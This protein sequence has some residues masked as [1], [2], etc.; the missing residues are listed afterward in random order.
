MEV[1]LNY[2]K[3]G[4]TLQLPDSW[5]L[6]LIRKKAVPVLPDPA[7]ALRKALLE[8]QGSQ[9]LRREAHGCSSACILICDVTRPVPNGLI[10]P[11]LLD[12][13]IQA[14]LKPEN[15]K[16]VV[17]TGL[18]RPNLG[19]ELADVVGS[20][21]VLNTV[22][23]VNHFARRDQDHV[24]LG[25]TLRGTPVKIDKRFVHADL[26]IAVGL[27]EPHFM[28]GYSGGRK[29]VVPGVA[30]AETITRL[31]TA[32]FL[33][34]CRAMNCLLERNPLHMEQMEIMS[35]IGRSLAVNVVITE[36]RQISF[37]NFGHID[38][39]HRAAVSFT[40]QYSEIPIKSKFPTVITSAAGYPLDDTYYQ[41]VKGM[42]GAMDALEPGGRLFI[43]SAC[44]KGLGSPEYAEAQRRLV[45]RG[46]AGFLEDILP[47]RHAAVDE[48][49]TEMQ[50]R[51]MR[52][53]S[54]S[55]FT[56]GLSP[57]DRALTG[58]NLTDSLE[59]SVKE[60]VGQIG[61]ARVAV[62]PE[63]PYVVPVYSPTGELETNR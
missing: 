52:V 31:H 3:T 42:V 33:E 56:E 23:V 53:G 50:L 22:E 41:T 24:D 26:R 57:E 8:P 44:E 17:A 30:H 58:I 32:D 12:E 39:S 47:K 11:V 61:D 29:V 62:I 27:V 2:G 5:D 14:G 13:L 20:R 4:L 37:V 25:R 48:W 34:D 49:Q 28:A 19:D 7:G 9:A 54:I 10:L 1:A 6:T 16:I 63:G 51:P 40:R 36:D 46:P 38:V 55:L 18:H 15:I 45:E 21:Q 60:W 35:M 59:K 43:A